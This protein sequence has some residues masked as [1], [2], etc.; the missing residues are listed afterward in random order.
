MII[1]MLHAKGGVLLWIKVDV[2]FILQ[3][4]ID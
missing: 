2:S 4:V 1:F 3:V